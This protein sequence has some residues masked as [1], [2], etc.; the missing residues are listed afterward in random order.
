[1]A[2][3]KKNNEELAKMLNQYKE[4]LA[5]VDKE[6]NTADAKLLEMRMELATMRSS[7]EVEAEVQRRVKLHLAKFGA[8]IRS[9]IDQTLG[10]SNTLTQLC[11]ASTRASQSQV[12]LG[13]SSATVQT[14]GVP[15]HSDVGGVRMR[16]VVTRHGRT[17]PPPSSSTD[18]SSSTWARSED[19]SPKQLS[20]VSPPRF[21]NL[22]QHL[23]LG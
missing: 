23:C 1:M 14:P 19:Q 3:L 17:Q 9:A 20:K 15:R 12:S 22:T 18:T 16:Q 21:A 7:P 10:L 6:R 8:D 4:A 2:A 13:S 11:V 5:R